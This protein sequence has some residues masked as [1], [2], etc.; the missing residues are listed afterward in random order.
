MTD[1]GK[2]NNDQDET[3]AHLPKDSSAGRESAWETA[4][5]QELRPATPCLQ[6]VMTLPFPESSITGR[7]GLLRGAA[8]CLHPDQAG[9]SKLTDRGSGLIVREDALQIISVRILRW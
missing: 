5:P 9:G 2:A 7:R 1:C 3:G 8:R 4:P 6:T